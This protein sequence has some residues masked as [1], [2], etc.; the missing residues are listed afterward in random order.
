M[1]TGWPLF[2][3]TNV[4]SCIPVLAVNLIISAILFRNMLNKE[5]REHRQ[6]IRRL[7]LEKKQLEQN[8]SQLSKRLT[9]L[10]GRIREIQSTQAPFDLHSR[11]ISPAETRVLRILCLYRASNK[12]IANRL[13]IAESTVKVHISHI[14]DKLGVEDRYGIIDLCQYNFNEKEDWD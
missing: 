2:S 5:L 11:G 4:V 3:L 9:V 12:Y 1:F 10:S 6:I 7:A 13:G 14:M 8:R